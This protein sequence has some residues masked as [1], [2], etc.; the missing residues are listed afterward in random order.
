[1]CYIFYFD[2]CIQDTQYFVL[3]I[4]KNLISVR[5][6]EFTFTNM[7]DYNLCSDLHKIPHLK[8]FK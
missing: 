2:L 4:Y 1:M 6:V 5:G 3:C 8:K 7:N